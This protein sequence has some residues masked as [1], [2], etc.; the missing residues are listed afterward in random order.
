MLVIGIMLILFWLRDV[1][2][3]RQRVYFE[4]SKYDK[5]LHTSDEKLDRK[6]IY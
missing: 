4:I 6:S 1:Q 3:W 5:F 2:I